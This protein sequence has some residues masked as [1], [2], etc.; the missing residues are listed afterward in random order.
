MTV[1]IDPTVADLSTYEASFS[2]QL[3]FY[4][5]GS[6][7]TDTIITS[8][9]RQFYFVDCSIYWDASVS[10]SMTFEMYR[11]TGLWYFSIVTESVLV[12]T[13]SAYCG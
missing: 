12:P 2:V 5:L 9:I 6:S 10:T 4:P 7:S 3:D 8:A 13:S 11:R 1:T